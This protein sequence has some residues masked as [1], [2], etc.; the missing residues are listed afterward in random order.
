M[1][2]R[3]HGCG[4]KLEMLA[5]IRVYHGQCDPYGRAQFLE[6]MLRVIAN[7]PIPEQD[8]MLAANMRKLAT[9]GLSKCGVETGSAIE[10]PREMSG[11]SHD[12]MKECVEVL[13]K[14]EWYVGE[15]EAVHECN[16]ALAVVT[17]IRSALSKLEKAT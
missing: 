2:S 15:Y 7:M 13:K 16:K 17:E 10:A 3:C 4:E 1:T 12:A 11:L 9:D 6:G 14:A 8:D 5:A